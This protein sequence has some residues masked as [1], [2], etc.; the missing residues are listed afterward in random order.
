M[1]EEDFGSEG[2]GLL[3]ALGV[4]GD[5]G[6]VLLDSPRSDTGSSTGKKHGHKKK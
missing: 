1:Q 4:S 6:Q 2:P 5:W 3:I